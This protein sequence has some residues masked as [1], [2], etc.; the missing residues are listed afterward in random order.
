MYLRCACLKTRVLHLSSTIA[1]YIRYKDVLAMRLVKARYK[2]TYVTI[3]S[4]WFSH[5]CSPHG[6][7][8]LPGNATLPLA[9]LREAQRLDIREGVKGPPCHGKSHGKNLE[10]MKSNGWE[11]VYHGFHYGEERCLYPAKHKWKHPKWGLKVSLGLG[12]N[13][14][15]HCGDFRCSSHV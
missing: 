1:R 9:E 10:M 2:V 3:P 7:S 13:Q 8:P 5:G 14:L 12:M 6:C 11:L 15:I 4:F